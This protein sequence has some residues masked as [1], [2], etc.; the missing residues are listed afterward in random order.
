LTV[1]QGEERIF[2]LREFDKQRGVVESAGAVRKVT[3]TVRRLAWINRAGT[4]N[5]NKMMNCDMQSAGAYAQDFTLE[6]W[7]RGGL[8]RI[9]PD[10]PALSRV[11]PP[12]PA[13]NFFWDKAGQSASF[14][15]FTPFLSRKG[16]DFSA[17]TANAGII[18]NYDPGKKETSTK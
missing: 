15:I 4:D 14:H 9:V 5:L 10:G 6:A 17:V 1:A 3:V 7:R 16:V 18:L 11:V 2:F 12:G 8:S 13:S